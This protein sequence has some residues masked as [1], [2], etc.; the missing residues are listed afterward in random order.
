MS[1]QVG[2][3]LDKNCHNG[4]RI[5]GDM[6]E[7][8]LTTSPQRFF[9]DFETTG[10][11]PDTAQVIEVALRGAASLDRLISDAPTSL[12]EALQVHGITPWL[13]RVEGRPSRDVLTELLEALGPDPV[14]IVAHNASFEQSFLEAWASREG[15]QLPGVQWTCTLEWS[16]NLM[17]KAPINHRLGSLAKSL[18]WQAEGLHRA[19]A[20][21]EL[22][23]RLYQAFKA[24]EGIQATLG[25]DPGAVY[26]A[27]PLR[28]DG[29]VTTIAHN[30][31]AMSTLARWAQAMLPRA[32]LLVPHLNFAFQD[33]SGGNGW[34]VRSQVLRSCERLVARCD[35]LILL[36][37]P[38]EGML[39]E[40]KV[41]DFLRIPVLC[42]PAWDGPDALP[43]LTTAYAG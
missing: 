28:G 21:T 5:V 14:E 29:L 26:L 15:M 12:P 24:W 1:T 2:R 31:Q 38:T 19:S 16:R 4:W 18:G 36:G 7:S 23:M 40:Q 9:L 8:S 10:L 11:S 27:G 25:P 17:A 22:T 35:A 33:E 6:T 13:C 20:D 41:A 34:S 3:E 37:E 42:A 39:G 43:A 30:Q 32:T